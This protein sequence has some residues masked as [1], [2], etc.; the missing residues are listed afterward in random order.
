M[1]SPFVF[2]FIVVVIIEGVSM[3]AQLSQ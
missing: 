2:V 3:G 1:T